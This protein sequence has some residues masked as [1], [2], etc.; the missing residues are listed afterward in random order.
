MYVYLTEL[1]HRENINDIVRS[2]KGASKF[3]DI[4]YFSMW[5]RSKKA[6][7]NLEEYLRLILD[8]TD[9]NTTLRNE[10]EKLKTF[11]TLA[12][13]ENNYIDKILKL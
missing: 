5:E 6:L 2:H 3:E 11:N 10:L 8:E 7:E 13:K 9:G 12:E 1:D 4:S